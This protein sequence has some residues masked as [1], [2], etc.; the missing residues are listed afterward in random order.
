[1]DGLPADAFDPQLPQLP[2]DVRVTNAGRLGDF[3]DQI[4][5][6]SQFELASFGLRLRFPGILFET[7]TEK[8]GWRNK[9]DQ[10]FDGLAQYLAELH[11][12]RSLIRSRGI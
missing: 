4:A 2:D 9:R 10:L 12:P 3:D 6:F 5:N 8:S 1:M 7:P 11:Q